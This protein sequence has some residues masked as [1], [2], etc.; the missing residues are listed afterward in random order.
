MFEVLRDIK[1]LT[2][3]S[4]RDTARKLRRVVAD[5]RARRRILRAAEKEPPRVRA[6]VGALAEAA[7]ADR[8]D[9][10]HLRK[11]L[12][13]TTRYDFGPLAVLPTA[14]AWGAR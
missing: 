5:E 2:D 3:L 8:S 1:H 14:R 7:G 10:L 12:N 13:P 6:M 11:T 9:L 4:P